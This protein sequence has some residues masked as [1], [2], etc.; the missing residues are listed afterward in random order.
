MAKTR[1]STAIMSADGQD[2]TVNS[3][4][5]RVLMTNKRLLMAKMRQ[6]MVKNK[7]ADRTRRDSRWLESADAEISILMAPGYW[8][9]R[10]LLMAK[11]KLVLVGSGLL[12]TRKRQWMATQRNSRIETAI[13]D[14]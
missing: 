12:M 7:T 11:S 14:C 8:L 1:L 6:K 5:N 10:R 2:E 3:I 9:E 13:R 4:N